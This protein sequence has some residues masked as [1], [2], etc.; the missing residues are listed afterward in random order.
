[1]ESNR[2]QVGDSVTWTKG[3]GS[4]RTFRW[5]LQEGVIVKVI[6]DWATA[7]QP[8]GQTVHLPIYRFRQKGVK[9]EIAEALR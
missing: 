1:V 3:S 4:G 5:Q 2:I 9:T 8:N 6:T 7:R